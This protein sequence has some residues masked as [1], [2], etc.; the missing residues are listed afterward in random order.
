VPRANVL[1]RCRVWCV[2][3]PGRISYQASLGGEE[4]QVGLALAAQ[5]G[6]VDLDAVDAAR[7]GQR[8]CLRLD[9]LRGEDASTVAVDT[10]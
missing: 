6:E 4:G 5:H 8:P 7:L 2:I 3:R 1:I 9:R 10:F